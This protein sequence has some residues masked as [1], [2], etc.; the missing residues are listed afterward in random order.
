MCNKFLIYARFNEIAILNVCE[1]LENK[2]I[3][4]NLAIENAKI[5]SKIGRNAFFKNGCQGIESC[6][7]LQ[8]EETIDNEDFMFSS[9]GKK[10]NGKVIKTF[11]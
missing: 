10:L 2:E 7:I 3:D 5:Q 9:F 1:D 6:F 4:L 8:C 11:F